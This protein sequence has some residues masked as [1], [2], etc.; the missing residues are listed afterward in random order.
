MVTEKPNTQELF[1]LLD[2]TWFEFSKLVSSVDA[3][4]INKMPFENS[5]TIA[6]VATHVKKSNNAIIQGLQ[7]KGRLSEKDPEER[8]AE[9]KKI[10]LDFD[11]K[12]QSPDFIIPDKKEYKKEA[13]VEQLDSSIG[14]LKQ[15]RNEINPVEII[16]LPIFGEITKLEILHFVL[17]HTQRHVHQLKNIL[18]SINNKN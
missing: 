13:V 7:M 11:A 16:N 5:W 17:Y 18:Q 15:L 4:I 1:T 9:L 3:H 6:Q 10:F 8:V 12:Y 2:K 14:Q